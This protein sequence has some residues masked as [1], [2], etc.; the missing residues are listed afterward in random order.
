MS[1]TVSA[2][3]TY[4]KS[5][6]NIAND[7][8]TTNALSIGVSIPLDGYLPWSKGADSVAS[9]ADNVKTA[10]LTL[11]NSRTTVAIQIDNYI[12][13]IRQIQSQ[14]ASLQANVDLAKKSYDMTKDA[15]NHGSRDLLSLQT[16]S[17]SLLNAR[18]DLAQQEYTL[19]TKIINLEYTLGVPFGSLGR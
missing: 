12:K 13:Q 17:D 5:K 10:E 4:G 9:A 19:I 11:E 1:P 16:A 3:W 7:F 15:Y 6:T 18:T 2:G 14:I 8:S